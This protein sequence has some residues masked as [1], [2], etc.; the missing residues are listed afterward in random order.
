MRTPVN[1][2]KAALARGERQIGIW[3]TLCS[4]IVTEI[5]GSSGVDW[6]L[7]DTEHTPNE[8]AAV[9]AQ[10]QAMAA[11]TASPIVRPAWNDAVLIKRLMDVGANTLLIPFVQN[12]AEAL[13]AVAACKY[14]P[15]GIRGI[16]ASARASA[17]GRMTDYLQRAND[18]TCVLVQ[19]E[20]DIAL[21][22]IN[23]IAAVPG[24]DGVFVGPS[25]LAASMGHLGDPG[26]PEVQLAI[27]SAG[28][29]LTALGKPAGILAGRQEEAWRYLDWGYSF[30]AVGSDTRFL[31][32]Q[33]A[34]LASAFARPLDNPGG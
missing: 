26:H 13:Q 24:V 4:P 9:M 34:D 11:G 17:Y 33:S 29:R 22:A 21:G 12:E 16:S 3:S 23:R 14:P 15:V 19:A 32:Q 8:P 7:I 10:L 2:F 18:E 27:R 30:V 28:Q 5:L 31:M 25:D 20:T 1:R 6:V